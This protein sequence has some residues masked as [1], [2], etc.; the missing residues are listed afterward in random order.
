MTR[1]SSSLKGRKRNG[2]RIADSFLVSWLCFS[3]LFY[4]IFSELTT[5]YRFSHHVLSPLL[6]ITVNLN[7]AIRNITKSTPIQN[8]VLVKNILDLA[9]FYFIG[10]DFLLRNESRA[11]FQ[12]KLRTCS[13]PVC[14][15]IRCYQISEVIHHIG[16]M[17]R[18][19]RI[20]QALN[21]SSRVRKQHQERTVNA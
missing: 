13:I 7:N 19:H 11:I 1:S 16:A 21:T 6:Q 4:N 10:S 20:C 2:P 3:F 9:L 15:F 12:E 18:S 5:K 14:A 8:A 17:S